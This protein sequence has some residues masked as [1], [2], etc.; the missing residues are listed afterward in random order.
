MT[1]EFGPGKY[2]KWIQRAFYVAVTL[3]VA[4]VIVGQLMK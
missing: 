2:R 4:V 3:G 1:A